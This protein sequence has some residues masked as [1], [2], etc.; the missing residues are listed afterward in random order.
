M[1]AKLFGSKASPHG[2]EHP[3]GQWQQEVH[4][5]LGIHMMNVVVPVQEFEP[6]LS[7]DK[8]MQTW[9]VN[10]IMHPHEQVGDYCRGCN[11]SSKKG[12][13]PGQYPGR[14]PDAQ[15]CKGHVKG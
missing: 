15:S 12:S 11:Q 10:C 8:A 14:E 6:G 5:G 3:V 2:A 1:P 7:L 9:I 4:I 13:V